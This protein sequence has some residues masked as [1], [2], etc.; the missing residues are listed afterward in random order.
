[1]TAAVGQ[2]ITTYAVHREADDRGRQ[3]VVAMI[4]RHVRRLAFLI[5]AE[6]DMQAPGWAG[7]AAKYR[8]ELATAEAALLWVSTQ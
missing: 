6:T 3:L 8:E 7:R 2:V 1:V 4:D 5:E